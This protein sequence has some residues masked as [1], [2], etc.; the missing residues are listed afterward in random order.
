MREGCLNALG[1]VSGCC[2][3]S[4]STGADWLRNV[5]VCRSHVVALD[6]GS[7]ADRMQIGTEVV[8]D[9]VSVVDSVVVEVMP[10]KLDDA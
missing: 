7:D 1:E 8:L 4:P 5:G 10:I 3:S 6:C 9:F 2:L